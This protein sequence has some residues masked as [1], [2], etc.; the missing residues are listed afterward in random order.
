MP[1]GFRRGHYHTANSY[2]QTAFIMSISTRA[3][4]YANTTFETSRS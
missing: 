2:M 3:N 4:P 1:I